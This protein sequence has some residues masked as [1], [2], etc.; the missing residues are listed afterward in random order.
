MVRGLWAHLLVCSNSSESLLG[1]RHCAR[2]WDGDARHGFK[3]QRVH[4]LK[5]QKDSSEEKNTAWCYC[6]TMLA[7]RRD[8][9]KGKEREDRE[10]FLKASKRHI[11]KHCFMTVMYMGKCALVSVGVR[12]V[13]GTS[14]QEG[15]TFCVDN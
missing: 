2:C 12:C 3:F 4:N 9:R 13:R 6:S 8:T 7:Q 14:R 5:G 11:Q 15:W 10:S 1:P